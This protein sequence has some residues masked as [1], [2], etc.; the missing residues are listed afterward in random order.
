MNI[1]YLFAGLLMLLCVAGAIGSGGVLLIGLLTKKTVRKVS[2]SLGGLGLVV[3]LLSLGLVAGCNH[4]LWG[5]TTDPAA[6]YQHAFHSPP[7]PAATNLQGI[8]YYGADSASRYLQFTTD[9]ATFRSI[10][11]K[12]LSRDDTKGY[13]S[14]EPAKWWT[15]AVPGQTEFYYQSRDPDDP[16][17]PPG[18]PM[19]ERT[20][21]T[22]NPKTGVVQFYWQAID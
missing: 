1:F 7:P 19:S 15:P 12:G 13:L 9:E 20:L 14:S 6:V 2:L 8:A 10:L 3:S 17:R 11:P 4:L 16:G 22:W 21:M 5:P 18:A